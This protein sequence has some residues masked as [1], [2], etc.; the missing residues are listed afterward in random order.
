MPIGATKKFFWM[1]F[2]QRILLLVFM[3][4]LECKVLVPGIACPNFAICIP[5][6]VMRRYL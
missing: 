6:F 1:M 5:I 3:P 4:V 2:M